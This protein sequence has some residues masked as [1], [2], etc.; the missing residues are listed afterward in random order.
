MDYGE[1]LALAALFVSAVALVVVLDGSEGAGAIGGV[2]DQLTV[3]LV[4]VEGAAS[5]G[6]SSVVMILTLVVGLALLV[7]LVVAL[8]ARDRAAARHLTRS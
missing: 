1:I 2:R 6:Q 8:R 5:V 7:A 3:A 4:G